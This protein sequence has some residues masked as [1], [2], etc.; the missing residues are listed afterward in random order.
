LIGDRRAT[1]EP[2]P[3]CLPTTK[4]WEWHTGYAVTDFARL[5]EY[6]ERSKNKGTLWTP[7]ATDGATAAI[8]VPNLL[9][10]PNALVHLLR[11][12][13]AVITPY[14]VLATI[15]GYLQ[16]G[17]APAEQ[18]WEHV[19]NWCLVASQAGANGKSKV[20]LETS[21]VTI[22]KEDFDKWVAN[23]LSTIQKATPHQPT[24]RAKENGGPAINDGTKRNQLMVAQW[25]EDVN[26][27]YTL[28]NCTSKSGKRKINKC[29]GKKK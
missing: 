18:E 3:I 4:S 9:A 10:I 24:I 20:F 28:N 26:H 25:P 17:R 13:G 1:K 2:T 7:G 12:Q 16:E 23:C 19:R 27:N 29:S 14:D 15:D 11:N 22:D 8:Q 21:P 5:A 6:Y